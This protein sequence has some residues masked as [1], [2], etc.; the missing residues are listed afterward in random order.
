MGCAVR[1]AGCV[2]RGAGCV[3]RVAWC[4]VRGAGCGVRDGAWC[5]GAPL[6]CIIMFG[7]VRT[8]VAPNPLHVASVHLF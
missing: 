4:V 2:V 5:V 3:A 7:G 8:L 1:G 6:H